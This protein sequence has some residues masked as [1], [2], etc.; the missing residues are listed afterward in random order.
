MF[1]KLG[2]ALLLVLLFNNVM[3]ETLEERVN[4]IDGRVSDLE[5]LNVLKKFVINGSFI[6]HWETYSELQNY[7][8][9]NPQGESVY[10]F[11]SIF[12][13]D[14]NAILTKNLAIYSRLGM[15]KLWNNESN[16]SGFKHN[17][18]DDTWNASNQ[19]S[20]GYW[21]STPRFDRAYLS[22]RFLNDNANF[23]I[24]RMSTHNGPPMHQEF[25]EDRMGTYPRLAYNAIFD[26]VAFFYHFKNYLDKK[27]HNLRAGIFYTPFVNIA[28][29]SRTDRRVAK[30]SN[31]D[32]HKAKPLT[33]QYNIQVEYDREFTNLFKLNLTYFYYK[34][35]SFF[36]YIPE[37]DIY[38][39]SA[40]ASSYFVG[41]ERIL[42]TNLNVN[43]SHLRVN[44]DRTIVG[45][46]EKLHLK[47][48][49]WLFGLNYNFSNV[50]IGA[51]KIE[52]SENYYIDDWTYYTI[53]DFY[54]VP[55]NK[56][57]HVYVSFPIFDL[58]KLKIG[59]FNYQTPGSNSLDADG[60][61]KKVRSVYATLKTSF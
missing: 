29:S 16:P 30:D 28:E 13:L 15:S 20:F 42:N 47:S 32:D 22:Y 51:E 1:K 46:K 50:I 57:E 59:V 14:I 37:D 24:G 55:N 9:Q 49:G 44:E 41:L 54:R 10:I 31:G 5:I 18:A 7:K 12:Q 39:L 40:R 26:G 21:G 17:Q 34:Y 33:D 25:G 60:T 8:T 45:A 27:K 53:S 35:V 36:Q 2:F 56:G 11:S 48:Y 43:I 3:S 61:Q 38:D 52:T 4:E 23:S 6:N 19:G 58:T